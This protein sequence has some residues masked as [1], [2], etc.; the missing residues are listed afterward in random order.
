MTGNI[1]FDIVIG[2]VFTYLLYSLY[3]TILM[4]LISSALGLRA[5]NLRY[6]LKRMLADEKQYANR[7][8]N[9]LMSVVT[10]FVRSF[11]FSPK[12][13]NHDLYD[14]F[15]NEPGIRYLGSG[16]FGGRPS[17]ISPE[18]FSKGVI[19]SVKLKDEDFS[20]MVSFSAGL[21]SVL[22]E[23]SDTKAH[24]QSL[25]VDANY[26]PVKFRILLEEW[27]H[28]TMDRSSGW[29]KQTTQF[30]VLFIGIFIVVS[31]NVNTLSII[32]K[33]SVDKDAR[34]QMV[35]MATDFTERN[36]SSIQAAQTDSAAPAIN[37]RLDSL[38]A[39]RAMLEKD[40][41]NAQSILS[42]NWAIP[43]TVSISNVSPIPVYP[44]SVV[45]TMAENS[46][47]LVHNSVDTTILRKILP[48]TNAGNLLTLSAGS[49]KWRY[50]LSR[51]HFLGFLLSVLALSLGAPFW[52]DL[53]NK[54]VR[55]RTSNTAPESTS[56]SVASRQ[57]NAVYNREILN[58]VG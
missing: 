5:K 7:P 16:G 10:T 2:L 11:G 25:M 58:R 18:N 34:E 19:D 48:A 3:A 47:I 50:V 12:S 32:K 46:Y 40:I 38:K 30:L 33:L 17:Y 9:W 27:Y 42:S 55:L 51:D 49:Y 20:L 22:P 13:T 36:A 56:N 35:K 14:R 21:E 43:A 57:S 29:F 24:I 39:V 52:F 8:K 23:N 15:Q 26:D 44:D 54:L 53:L 4:E 31:F 6:T 41:S 45:M 37:N 28:S 1:A